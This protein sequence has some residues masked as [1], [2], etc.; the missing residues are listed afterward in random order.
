MKTLQIKFFFAAKMK[1][2][3]SN[4]NTNTEQQYSSSCST[5]KKVL[6]RSLKTSSKCANCGRPV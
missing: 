2:A 3:T 6:R 4:V 5:W 1:L